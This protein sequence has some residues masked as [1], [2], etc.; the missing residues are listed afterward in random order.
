[1]KFTKGGPNKTTLLYTVVVLYNVVHCCPLVY[2]V[3]HC[4]TLYKHQQF[5]FKLNRH[6]H[7]QTAGIVKPS[8]D[9]DWI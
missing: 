4:C 5:V 2:T 9:A 6:R 1:M 7:R 3:V 8:C